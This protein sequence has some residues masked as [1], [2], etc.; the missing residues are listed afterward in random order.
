MKRLSLSVFVF[1]CFTEANT[2]ILKDLMEEKKLNFNQPLLSVRRCSSTV[3]NGTHRR[4]KTDNSL[5]RLKPLPAYKS[6]LKSV[7][8]RNA[9]TV[10]FEWEKAPGKPK[11]ESKLQTQAVEQPPFITPNFPL[12]RVS[13]IQQQSVTEMRTGSTVADSERVASLDKRVRKYSKEEIKD[14]ESSYSDDGDESY[15]DALDILS[16]SESF[17]TSCS[18]SGWDELEA[19]YGSFSSDQQLARDFMIDRTSEAPLYV[20]RKAPVGQEQQKQEKKEVNAETSHPLNQHRPK[21]LPHNTQD[22]DR[23]ENEDCN[24]YEKCATTTCGLFPRFCLLNPM[25]GLRMDKVERMPAHRM[26]AKS[27]AS[28]IGSTKEQART[29]CGFTEEKDILDILVKSKHG[30]DPRQRGCSRILSSE[31]TQHDY[32]SHVREKTLYVDSV[33]EATSQT[34]TTGVDY[35]TSRRDSGIYDNPS[36]DSSPKMIGCKKMNSE[37]QG[38][39]RGKNSNNL[40]Q[41]S[42]VHLKSQ[43]SAKWVD[44]KCTLNSSK[45]RYD[46]KLGHQETPGASC[47]GLPL[48]L[49]SLKAPAESW[50]KRT[51]PTISKKKMTSQSNLFANLHAKCHTPKTISLDAMD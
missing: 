14:K 6:E 27:G 50:L 43:L 36:I 9:G 46:E 37:S 1:C 4:S 47:F 12:G 19:P 33:L 31:S 8:V 23:D 2:M 35:E 25:L 5:D 29:P 24:E 38:Y 11:D 48:V 18:M 32:E 49:P 10:P 22:I 34:N 3:A 15:K 45:V 20:S 17:F 42:E 44:K 51:L 30:T 28:H 26:Q 21:A 16:R 39:S 13:E 40:N 41:D 7:P